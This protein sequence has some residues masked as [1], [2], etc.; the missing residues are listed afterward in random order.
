MNIG[1]LWFDNDP[2]TD[3]LTK[4]D[5]AAAYYQRKYGNAPNQCYVN[6]SML[7]PKK[8][9]SP[10]VKISPSPTILPNHLWIGFNAGL[11]QAAKSK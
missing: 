5:Q 8:V 3:L 10:Q 7:E 1:M 2:K 9:N 6:P 4:I 11:K